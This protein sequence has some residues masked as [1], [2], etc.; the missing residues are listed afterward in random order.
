MHKFRVGISTYKKQKCSVFCIINEAFSILRRKI[1]GYRGFTSSDIFL[2]GIDD[3]AF[4]LMACS[5]AYG[6]RNV[7]AYAVG[8]RAVGHCN[9][10]VVGLNQLDFVNCEAVVQSYGGYCAELTAVECF[11]ENDVCNVHV[12]VVLSVSVGSNVDVSNECLTFSVNL[13]S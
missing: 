10:Q 4:K 9:E 8:I 3:C 6:V 12:V 7:V 1:L 11:S 2:V 13:V 5:F